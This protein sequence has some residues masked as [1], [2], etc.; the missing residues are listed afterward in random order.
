[1]FSLCQFFANP[2]VPGGLQVNVFGVY[3]T[4]Q[5]AEAVLASLNNPASYVIASAW[6]YTPS[7]P[8]G[9]LTPGTLTL[10][11]FVGVFALLGLN[12]TYVIYLYTPFTTLARRK[13]GLSRSPDQRADLLPGRDGADASLVLMHPRPR[14]K[15]D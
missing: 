6:N 2:L 3:A 1:M 15:G 5:A 10:G 12:G 7:V 14:K 13:R 11:A 8:G 9:P 4:Y